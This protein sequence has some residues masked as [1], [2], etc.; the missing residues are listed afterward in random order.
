M[1]IH[2]DRLFP[3]DPT[4]RAVA[5]RLYETV[6]DLPIVSPH[7]H[8]DPRWYAEN[9]PFP[10]P[11]TLFV[12]P[13]TTSSAC[14]TARASGWRISA[15]PARGRQR[16]RRDPRADL[17][18]VRRAL[19]SLP[20]HADAALARSYLRDPV[21]VRGAP[22]G[23]QRG[24]VLRSDRR[25]PADAGLPPAGPV[26]ALQ[27]RGHRHHREPARRARSSRDDPAIRLER[28]RHHGLS[29]RSGG[30]SGVSGLSRQPRA[31]RRADRMRYVRP[32]PATSTRIATAGRSSARSAR[33][34]PT[35]AIRPRGPP[36]CL[37]RRCGG[38]VRAGRDRR[39]RAA[40]RRSCSAP[41][42]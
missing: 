17:A 6:R 16:P 10:D 39:G 1:L 20:R 9:E 37:A 7:G 25:R 40:A 2:E 38:P 41:R 33:P 36:T 22:L 31:V 34:P 23:R 8:T 5:R 12:S 13:I 24:R 3:V 32:G 21:R 35:M 28:P 42:C 11:A 26:R 15:I 27:H 14:S 19:S 4:A 18:A 29:A 30:R